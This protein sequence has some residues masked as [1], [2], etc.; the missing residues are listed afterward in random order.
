MWLRP[1]VWE[2][3][4]VSGVK[5]QSSQCQPFREEEGLITE[6]GVFI[7]GF[8]LNSNLSGASPAFQ[9]NP[10]QVGCEE[11]PTAKRAYALY[12][13]TIESPVRWLIAAGEES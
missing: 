2:P 13:I 11:A 10:R 5:G 8:R 6:V 12:Q 7:G 9:I 4:A 3:R 1:V